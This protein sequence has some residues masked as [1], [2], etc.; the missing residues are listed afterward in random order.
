MYFRKLLTIK[1]IFLLMMDQHSWQNIT[2]I[3]SGTAGIPS[4]TA[5]FS[6]VDNNYNCLAIWNRN[7][8]ILVKNYT[9]NHVSII[10]H[11]TY[12]YNNT[13]L[14]NNKTDILFQDNNTG[15][16]QCNSNRRSSKTRATMGRVKAHVF[17]NY[18]HPNTIHLIN[19]LRISTRTRPFY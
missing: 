18:A 8:I 14:Y 16:N 2:C 11:V 5:G 17:W 9:C 12:M 3:P 4:G 6:R 15:T 1:H 19:R 10:E 7:N 13:V